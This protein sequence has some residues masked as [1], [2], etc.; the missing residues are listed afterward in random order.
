M[1]LFEETRAKAFYDIV[2]DTMKANNKKL[3]RQLPSVSSLLEHEEVVEWLNEFPR[4]AIVASLKEAL[5]GFRAS[6]LE[7]EIESEVE[8]EDILDSA[9]AELERRTEPSLR[10]VI[11]A[12]GIIL[13]T[14]LGRA[15][16][17]DAAIEA[18][19]EGASGY[20]NLEYDLTTG[21]RGK[22]QDH[23][24]E[25]LAEITG[26]EAATVVNNNAAAT[27]L[28]LQVL[29]AGKEVVV[30]RGQ[31][32]EIGGSFRLPDIMSASGAM[33]REVGT[34]NRTR[35]RDYE[36]AINDRTAILMLAHPSN[37]RTVGFTE[38]V[39]LGP[40]VELAHEYNLLAVH[41]LGSGVMI[42]PSELGMGGEPDVL[43]SV[44]SDA[45]LTCFSG[46]KLLGGPQCGVIVGT[47]ELVE[48]INQSPLA[49][50]YRVGKLTLLALEATLRA[51]LDG[52]HVIEQIPTLSMID[53][54][55]D[56]LAERAAKLSEQLMA[57]LP[58]E[59][60]YV[61]SDVSFAGGGSMPDQ[62]IPTVVVQWQPAGCSTDEVVSALREAEVPVVARVRDDAI[63][64]DLRTIRESDF[65]GLVTSVMD[66]VM[67]VGE[68]DEED[69]NDL[70]LPVV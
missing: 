57:E 49:R 63:C 32:V 47:A 6:I 2:T 61:C 9:E 1:N 23:V 20:C 26:A 37:F 14:G 52:E 22:R 48:K 12:T 38:S 10:N 8:V 29:A 70:S 24:A 59:R 69:S 54:S 56:K 51:Y 33:L 68:E 5:E 13:H 18:I 34:T 58:K 39:P 62:E 4:P 60:F 21:S 15:P 50:T 53:A 67:E 31:L 66:A 55:T 35:L 46:D 45:D 17:C 65:E 30:S 28:I 64:F 40:M 44:A 27:Y 11:N 25:L 36:Q 3:L 43:S 41:D 42:D 16:L 19:V 7:G